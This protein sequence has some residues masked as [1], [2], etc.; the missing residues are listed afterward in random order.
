MDRTG[1]PSRKTETKRGRRGGG[2]GYNSDLSCFV[3]HRP[4]L[5]LTVVPNH[6]LDYCFQQVLD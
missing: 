1:I 2:G 5:N 6:H 4:R 3:L